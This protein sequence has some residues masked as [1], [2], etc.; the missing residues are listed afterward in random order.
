MPR[1]EIENTRKIHTKRILKIFIKY[2]SNS[3]IRHF[4]V[5]YFPWMQMKN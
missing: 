1:Y 3:L 2:V 4:Q 5:I